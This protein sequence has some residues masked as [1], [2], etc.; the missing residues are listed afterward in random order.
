MADL[1]VSSPGRGR[2]KAPPGPAGPAGPAGATQPP[3]QRDPGTTSGWIAKIVLLGLVDAVAITGLVTAVEAEAWGY[4]AVL[5]VT[6]V[7][8]NVVYLPRRFVPMKYL[9]PGLFFLAVFALYPVLYT[10]YSSTT[11]YGTGFVLSKS[12]AIAQIQS[13]SIS[14]TEGTVAYDATPLAGPDGRFAGYALYDPETEELFLGTTDGIEP[15]DEPAELQVLTTTGRTFIVSVGEYRGVRPGNIGSLPGYPSDPASYVMPGTAEGSEIRISGGQAVESRPTKAYD[16]D[17]GVIVDTETG[18]V[19]TP[20]DGRFTSADGEGLNPGFT[21][22]VGFSNYSEVLTGAEFRGAF[23]RVLLWTTVFALLSVVV[24]FAVGLGL[25]MVFDDPRMRG[26]KIYRSLVII[27]YALPAFMTALVWRGLLNRTFGVNRWLGLDIGWLEST[28]LAMFSLLLVNLWLGYPYMFLVST[29]ALQSIPKDLKEAAYVDGAT[30]LTTFRKVTFPLLLTAVSPLLI[31]SFAFNFNN[32]TIV[33][34]VTGGR[35][36]DAGESA[37]T[38]D[39]LLSWTY[40]IALD[41]DP[42]RQGLAAAV[43]VLIFIIVAVLSAI[44]FK[45]TKAYEE[46]R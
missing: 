18:T 41:S 20:V 3:R 15:L 10:A 27:P 34:L 30:G 35:P 9:L 5:A 43:A 12:Q 36:R 21:T 46:I 22:N 14:R 42:K 4:V 32:F 1:E 38:T 31:A 17:R 44:G 13:Q 25:A 33:Y 24:T 45:Y 6:L 2:V 19:Y 39:I 40:R 28:P 8:L 11:N 16:E 37:G 26:R 29:G 7:A 23:P